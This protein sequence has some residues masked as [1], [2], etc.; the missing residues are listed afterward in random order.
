MSVV[1]FPLTVM[2]L[3]V[4]VSNF[5]T[6]TM[7][8]I[9]RDLE[10]FQTLHNGAYEMIFDRKYNLYIFPSTDLPREV[11]LELF[12]ILQLEF[13]SIPHKEQRVRLPEI[14]RGR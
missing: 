3:V 2:A 7:N 8:E 4:H 6:P 14:S 10:N 13:E 12:P 9:A 5:E 11:Q 1:A